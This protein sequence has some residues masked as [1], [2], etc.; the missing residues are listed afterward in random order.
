[1]SDFKGNFEITP[2]KK[3]EWEDHLV[4]PLDNEIL[5]QGTPLSANNLNNIENGIYNAYQ[6][7]TLLGNEFFNELDKLQTDFDNYL[8]M[9]PIENAIVHNL[10]TYPDLVV[11][12]FSNGYGASG[13]GTQLYS[14]SSG[15]KLRYSAEYLDRNSIKI[16]VENDYG[17]VKSIYGVNQNEYIITFEAVIFH[18]F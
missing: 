16:S 10:D 11:L 6:F 17:K 12:E 5:Q 2:Y 8:K 9:Y 4:D 7:L 13:Y 14:G 3:T 18:C 1:M 15:R